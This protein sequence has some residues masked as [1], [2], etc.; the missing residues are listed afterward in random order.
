MGAGGRLLESARPTRYSGVPAPGLWIAVLALLCLAWIAGAGKVL[1]AV[2]PAF[3]VTFARS[4]V[5]GALA[6]TPGV[7]TAVSA[8]LCGALGVLISWRWG[9]PG[10][11]P[12]LLARLR[13]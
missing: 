4:G 12:R 5:G 8:A 3:G 6:L 1:G 2:F 11:P 10:V 9:L 13:K 7:P